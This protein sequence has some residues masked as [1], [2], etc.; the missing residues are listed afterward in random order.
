M[1]AV[2]NWLQYYDLESLKREFMECGLAID[3]IFSDVSG[4]PY[5]PGGNEIAVIAKRS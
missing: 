4:S 5:D 2:Y 1:W 3:E